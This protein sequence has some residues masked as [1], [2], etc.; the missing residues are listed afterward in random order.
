MLCWEDEALRERFKPYIRVA[1]RTF[2]C[3][4]QSA[5]ARDLQMPIFK[6]STTI[7]T[8]STAIHGLDSSTVTDTP[9]P[10]ST[11]SIGG[12]KRVG[13][14]D[15]RPTA[16]HRRPLSHSPVT[17]HERGL[18]VLLPRELSPD[19]F[20]KQLTAELGSARLDLFLDSAEGRNHLA[21]WDLI[22]PAS[23]ASPATTSAAKIRG[24]LA[25][26]NL[27]SLTETPCRPPRW[28]DRACR[29]RCN[30]GDDSVQARRISAVPSCI[31]SLGRRTGCVLSSFY[32]AAR[33]RNHVD[34]LSVGRHSDPLHGLRARRRCPAGSLRRS[35]WHA[36]DPGGG[37]RCLEAE[38][39]V[40]SRRRLEAAQVRSPLRRLPTRHLP[41]R[42]AGFAAIDDGLRIIRGDR[43]ERRPAEQKTT[44]RR[45]RVG[46]NG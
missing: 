27:S 35:L 5:L 46:E 37:A 36:G 42:A 7:D 13:P 10:F 8:H 33:N 19:A 41:R 15:D 24:A 3:D 32:G 40:V 45:R 31:E 21:A 12:S 20:D 1:V 26:P 43:D 29:P 14:L 22:G 16:R 39:P 23:N 2:A 30:H 44:W 11:A 34:A 18:D 9:P 38:V 28:P 6:I 25:R 4:G 17:A